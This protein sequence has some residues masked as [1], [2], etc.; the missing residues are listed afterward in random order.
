MIGL[1]L[2]DRSMRRLLDAIRNAPIEATH[3]ALLKRPKWRVPSSD[4]LDR[5][6]DKA[7]DYYDRFARSGVKRSPGTKGPNWRDEISGILREVQNKASEQETVVLKE[8]G[9]KPIWF[10]DYSDIPEK[11]REIRHH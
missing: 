1:S 3:F 9:I 8:L 7:Q 5:I 2:S 4:E 6:H 10:D 11:L